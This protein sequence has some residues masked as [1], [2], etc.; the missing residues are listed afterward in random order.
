[1]LF[2]CINATTHIKFE[3]FTFSANISKNYSNPFL[4]SQSILLLKIL[5][6]R[7]TIEITNFILNYSSFSER[8]FLGVSF[9]SDRSFM[10][11]QNL[12][13]NHISWE[14]F[15]NE[16]D[17]SVINIDSS[18]TIFLSYWT[19]TY[20]NF[21]APESL[22]FSSP[23]SL[24]I[25]DLEIKNSCFSSLGNYGIS[26]LIMSYY[27]FIKNI[28][29]I[30]SYVSNSQI[31]VLA[32]NDISST[33][34]ITFNQ[35]VIYNST[36]NY[37]ATMMP[38]IV[39]SNQ[40]QN[41]NFVLDNFKLLNC[42]RIVLEVEELSGG[43]F[44]TLFSLTNFILIEISNLTFSNSSG[45]SGIEIYSS[46]YIKIYNI[47][48]DMPF[49]ISDHFTIYVTPITK[50]AIFSNIFLLG[51]RSMYGII[52]LE[53]QNIFNVI[54]GEISITQLWVNHVLIVATN[55]DFASTI[56][57]YSEEFILLTIS[58]STFFDCNIIDETLKQKSSSVLTLD[59][60]ISDIIIVSVQ[61][62]Q[63]FSYNW[64]SVFTIGAKSLE[65][66]NCTFNNI[67]FQGFDSLDNSLLSNGGLGFLNLN[68]LIISNSLFNNSFGY[69]GGV[70]YGTFYKNSTI[71][72]TSCVFNNIFAF[73]KGGVFYFNTFDCSNMLFY[74]TN[75]NFTFIGS[76]DEGGLISFE[77]N[78]NT[79][80]NISQC[81]FLNVNSLKSSLIYA[82]N[83]E[84]IIEK[85]EISLVNIFF[86]MYDNIV[87]N[88]LF[89]LYDDFSTS[90]NFI[91]LANGKLVLDQTKFSDILTP[92]NSAIP[93]FLIL[94]C[95][96]DFYDIII[97]NCYFINSFFSIK[98]S[99]ISIKKS[100]FLNCSSLPNQLDK[101]YFSAFISL[102]GNSK[103]NLMNS[104][105][106][107]I[108][109]M[110]CDNGGGF[111]FFQD[112]V[113]LFLNN[114]IFKNNSAKYGS[115]IYGQ[116]EYNWLFDSINVINNT[117][118][119]NNYASKEAGA[120]FSIKKF[121]F[122]H[123]VSFVICFTHEYGGAIS[124][125][126]SQVLRMFNSLFQ[127]NYALIAGA[128]FYQFD[129]IVLE[130]KLSCTFINNSAY[131]FGNNLYSNPQRVRIFDMNNQLQKDNGD[132]FEI[133]DFRSG[134]ILPTISLQILD[135]EG[136]VLPYIFNIFN[137]FIFLEIETNTADNT[138]SNDNIVTINEKKMISINFDHSGFFNIS[139]IKLIAQPNST[140]KIKI[141]SPQ[142]IN[143]TNI[144][145]Y[146]TLIIRLRSC[147]VGELQEAIGACFPC[148]GG[149]SFNI[150]DTY[151]KKCLQGMI[152]D[153]FGQTYVDP[154]YW[155]DQIYTESI[156]LCEAE[157]K[158][159]GGSGFGNSLCAPG[160]IGAKCQSCDL[161]KIYWNSSYS[162]TS[163]YECKKCDEGSI[164]Y[165]FFILLT[166]LFF[167][168]MA[169]TVRSSLQNIKT[170]YIRK[171]IKKL[172]IYSMIPE[173][174]DETAI[175]IKIYLSYFQI[176]QVLWGLNW[177]YVPEDFKFFSLTLA[178]PLEIISNSTEC[179]IPYFN[180]KIPAIYTK[181]IILVLSPFI[182]LT[183][184][185]IIYFIYAWKQSKKRKISA[186]Y[187]VFFFS[188]IFFQPSIIK[189]TID[190]LTCVAIGEKAYIKANLAFYCDNEDYPFYSLVLAF[191]TLFFWIL[192]FPGFFFIKVFLNRK[193]LNEAN[194][195][196]K[197]SYIHQEYKFTFWEFIRIS[198]KILIIIFLEFYENETIFKNLLILM[199][200]ACYYIL[201]T[202][203]KP[204]KI[205][206]QNKVE[207]ITS[208]ICF[209]SL[210]FGLL[211]VT[212]PVSYVL[213]SGYFIVLIINT[214]FNIY[215]LKIIYES[216]V[217]YGNYD[218][219]SKFKSL[220][221]L[222]I[223][224]GKIFHKKDHIKTLHLWQNVRRLVARY[225]RE[226]SRRNLD[227]DVK[228]ADHSFF[229]LSLLDYDPFHTGINNAKR[230]VIQSQNIKNIDT[231]NKDTEMKFLSTNEFKTQ[232]LSETRKT[233]VLDEYLSDTMRK[234][235]IKDLETDQKN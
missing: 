140:I 10:T 177:L 223:L 48:I 18:G 139:F 218:F 120:L 232:S 99:E 56:T 161:M 113:S 17:L 167:L 116:G 6:T 58:N 130:D 219:C 224:W 67:N 144:N 129:E 233:N 101:T 123:N 50:N 117:L 211:T 196:R 27:F 21:S 2:I 106:I 228:T 209:T 41:Q 210:F 225:L 181:L 5:S 84:L 74:I 213:Y 146:F 14:V 3:N 138:S 108:S 160:H 107:S 85:C 172:S 205:E 19:I 105:I 55:L 46:Q 44:F 204:Y 16:F 191:P 231:K 235:R 49:Q 80:L 63:T 171:F 214:I 87:H 81:L 159:L 148:S 175:Y 147:N 36:F 198:E 25:N 40:N 131:Y 28:F 68:D 201:L 121:F 22:L 217:I 8:N 24:I 42:T 35:L 184:F 174:K 31:F 158:C 187:T 70:L 178:H 20:S 169:I 12:I 103:F 71:S 65:F 151:C 109:C 179:L 104:N 69:R 51:I 192:L 162:Q 1:M 143:R 165:Y 156:I 11:I 215:F 89:R 134:D 97:Y 30:D 163:L 128:I 226:R 93:L 39:V 168:W 4:K 220:K 227:Q 110:E 124:V 132:Q 43:F 221:F 170:L 173:R 9:V 202:R 137:P 38:L 154:G 61:I 23:G 59:S 57:I 122:L 189:G 102:S 135:E 208:I 60:L 186:I 75:T 197:F 62:N 112:S 86:E 203:F 216:F 125:Y 180:L 95:I 142:I 72:I 188:L 66:T 64:T 199:V 153:D 26:T 157:E 45:F 194:N 114:I 94:N 111:L 79:I 182:Y 98:S 150:T 190:S 136:Y 115:C 166:T 207:K 96:C 222:L 82:E 90:S 76:I 83:I 195:L 183:T 47:V 7:G 88:P 91:Y 92:G 230:P 100:I 193:C 15:Q 126:G 185:L 77:S 34:P 145:Y 52:V 118:F 155:R 212:Y 141:S 206:N 119:L 127:N 33:G 152:C 200:I 229:N 73:N 164:N 53:T 13:F 54:E 234:L 176:I 37:N 133:I 32:K 78:E 149:Y 29:I